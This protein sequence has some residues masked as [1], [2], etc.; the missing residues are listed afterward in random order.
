M[1][2]LGNDIAWYKPFALKKRNKDLEQLTVNQYNI[3][4]DLKHEN[5]A[6]KTKKNKETN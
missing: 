2:N 6:I 3:L 1:K 4:M 5:K